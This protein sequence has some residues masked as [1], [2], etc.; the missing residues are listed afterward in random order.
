LENR[1]D[2]R[3]EEETLEREHELNEQALQRQES[4]EAQPSPSTH[5]AQ[6]TRFE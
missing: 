4:D 3:L 1:R 6:T 2:Q 5:A